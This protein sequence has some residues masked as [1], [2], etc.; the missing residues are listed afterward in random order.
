[1]TGQSVGSGVVLDI[2]RHL[3]KVLELNV[4]ERWVRVEPGITRDELNR[5]LKPHGLHF[6]PDPAT[7][8]RANIGGMISNNSAGMR[9]IQYGMTIDHLLSL[10]LALSSGEVIILGPMTESDLSS[11]RQD[12]TTHF[13]K[14]L[15]RIIDRE[16]NEIAVRFPRISRRAGGYA[17][18]TFIGPSPWNLAKL[19]AGSEGTLGIILEAKLNLESL[20]RH[21]ALCLA[22]FNG[23]RDCLQAV[24]SIMSFKPSAVELLDGLIIRQARQHPL[25]QATCSMIDGE[26]EALLIIEARS[27]DV[28]EVKSRLLGIQSTLM[29][30]GRCYHTRMV[31]DSTDVQAVWKMREHALGLMT[32]VEGDRKPTPYIEDAAVPLEV[33]PDYIDEVL[34][35]CRKHGQPVSLFAHAGAG[36][37]HI[38]PLHDLH[39]REDIDQMLLIQDEV[40]A[41]VKKYKGTWNGEHGAGIIRG[42]YNR[43]YFGDRIYQAFIE[44]KELFDPDGIMNPGK[45]V[46]S[47]A[48]DE[49]LRFGSYSQPL[50]VNTAYRWQDEG[51]LLRAAE[52]CTGIGACR[53]IKSGVMCPSYMATR[54]EVHST[55]GRA[56]VL[57]LALSGQLGNNAMQSDDVKA[58]F[59]LCIS[60]KGCK[61]ECPN[62][63]DVGKMKAELLFQYYQKHR[64]P[65]RSRLFANAARLGAIQSGWPAPLFNA[66]LHSRLFRWVL[67]RSLGIDARR[68]LPR[69]ARQPLSTWFASRE[70]SLG[71]ER[72]RVVLFNDTFTEYHEPE[73]GKAAIRVLEAAGFSVILFSADSQRPALSQGML[74]VAQKRGTNVIQRLAPYAEKKLPILVIEPSCATA[75]L[76]DLPDLTEHP[77]MAASVASHVHLLDN[78]L[79]GEL[80]AGRCS[81]PSMR[82]DGQTLLFHP[83]CHQRS[84]DGGRATLALLNLIQGA[85]I[86][87]TDAGCCGMAGSFGYEKDH[88]DLS[89]KIAEDRLLPVLR[90]CENNTI[91]VATGFSCRHQISDL[92]GRQA[93]HPVQVIDQL[94][95]KNAGQ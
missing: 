93:R 79:A 84:I 81:L 19:T 61:T 9:S 69:Y 6:A 10:D 11:D 16:R 76:Q 47:P 90:T 43:D 75:L 74:D 40:F 7:S 21:S 59:D 65:I 57:R 26:P 32:T 35:V 60:C 80:L 95:Q 48:R 58:V 86:K 70:K 2:S 49:Y 66:I 24:Q 30:S 51:N 71:D 63:V 4:S 20:P 28:A 36:L 78:F 53:Q 45:I 39:R 31:E 8:S 5:Q 50:P 92:S 41:L 68:P 72:M 55:R 82:A 85:V 29:A 23:L 22:H 25:T 88:Y 18:D 44:V 73:V 34:A 13:L 38:R 14:S 46:H 15:R 83:H 52:Q 91:V 12:R 17:L 67:D 42:G 94:I 37:L 3:N 77:D 64:R 54:D 27:N 33:L 62:K 1:L 56:N 87:S 89:V